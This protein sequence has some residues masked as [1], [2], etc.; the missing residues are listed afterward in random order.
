MMT[1]GAM[2]QVARHS[3]WR[4]IV[5][6]VLNQPPPDE[7]WYEMSS[8]VPVGGD[9]VMTEIIVRLD[10][11]GLLRVLCL[12]RLRVENKMITREPVNIVESRSHTRI[13]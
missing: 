7:S 12:R 5:D 13:G 9:L 8:K 10:M 4:R 2:A 6:R 11:L 1:E 3:L